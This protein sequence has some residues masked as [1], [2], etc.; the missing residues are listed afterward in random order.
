MSCSILFSSPQAAGTLS[1]QPPAFFQDLALD[2]VCSALASGCDLVDLKPWFCTPLS[3]FSAIRY[4]QQ[5]MA[6]FDMPDF[7]FRLRRATGALL[8]LEQHRTEVDEDLSNAMSGRDDYMTRCRCLHLASRYAASL[9]ELLAVFQTLSPR[10]EGIKAFW[11]YLEDLCS[12]SAFKSMKEKAS[13]LEQELLGISCTMLIR[14]GTF[15]MRPFEGEADINQEV[16]RLFSRFRQQD[17]PE[18]SFRQPTDTTEH[19]IDAQLLGMVSRWN[20]P[21]FASI[22]AFVKEHLHFFDETVLRFCRE[23]QFY[24]SWQALIAP[25]KERGL[26]FCYPVLEEGRSHSHCDDLFDLA[27]ALRLWRGEKTPITSSFTLDDPERI[28]VITGPNQGGKTTFA[29]AFGQL[30]Y[31]TALG[32][33][34]P[35]R[36]ARLHPAKGIYT[37]FNREEDLSTLSSRLQE[38]LVRLHD[39]LQQ[40]GPDSL[41]LINEIFASTTLEDADWLGR[42]MMEDLERIGCTAVCVTFLEELAEFSEHT[43]SMTGAV[44]PEDPARRT[45]KIERRKADG[46]AYADQLAKKYHLTEEELDR[47][48]AK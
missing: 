31:L 27:L 25:L 3:D 8:I 14:D 12:G 24:L 11:Q 23:A 5:V 47:R 36:N 46:M 29:R 19:M 45:F 9:E 41:V 44:D 2:K 15:R 34:V 30:Y 6:D 21:L 43:V 37:H 33:C 39:I 40:A 1:Q 16:E 17:G 18:R 35:G 4:R 7:T 26:A 38:E 13:K 42:K 32:C 48:L 28:L 10:S 22:T 20:K